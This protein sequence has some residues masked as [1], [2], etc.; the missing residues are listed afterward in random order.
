MIKVVLESDS[1]VT[2]AS[3]VIVLQEVLR[4]NQ[5]L[6]YFNVVKL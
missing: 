3:E 1:T 2:V 5:N 6:I 4:K